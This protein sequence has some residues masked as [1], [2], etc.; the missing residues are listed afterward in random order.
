MKVRNAQVA[1]VRK[2]ANV[3]KNDRV[4]EK[5]G[6]MSQRRKCGRQKMWTV[7]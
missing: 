5:V 3:G 7:T 4:C 1:N 6:T 2:K